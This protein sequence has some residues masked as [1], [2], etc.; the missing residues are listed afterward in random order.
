M[1]P[2]SSGVWS[3]GGVNSSASP[4]SGRINSRSTAAMAR[5]ARSL[6]A[7]PEI[8]A[9]DLRDRIDAA[10]FACRRAE[11][12]TVSN[13]PRKYQSPSHASRSSDVSAARRRALAKSRRGPSRGAHRR[14][15]QML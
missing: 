14:A 8:T 7:A 9:Q 4:S 11:R 13:Q 12:R 6:S 10:L 3:N 15:E 1:Y 5:A 2:G